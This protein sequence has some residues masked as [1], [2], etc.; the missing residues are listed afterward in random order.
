MAGEEFRWNIIIY[1]FYLYASLQICYGPLSETGSLN[2]WL[3]GW[4]WYRSDPMDT[5]KVL[6]KLPSCFKLS[7]TWKWA[8]YLGFVLPQSNST[9]F[10]QIS[11]NV[12]TREHRAPGVPSC[13]LTE[14]RCWN[15]DKPFSEFGDTR[16]LK[17]LS[18]KGSM[19]DRSDAGPPGKPHD[20]VFY[21]VSGSSPPCCF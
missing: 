20:T 5:P 11:R 2:N 21:W 7:V 3:F 9:V 4:T 14:N 1:S 17:T 12:C 8:I 16:G 19:T 6:K 18:T 10:L 15:L 13:W